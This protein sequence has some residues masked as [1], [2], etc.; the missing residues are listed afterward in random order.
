M[1]R[2]RTRHAP[3]QAIGKNSE[4]QA[5]AKLKLAHRG[6]RGDHAKSCRCRTRRNGV[7]RLSEIY[8][9]EDV[10]PLG[11]EAQ[12]EALAQTEV[13]RERQVSNPVTR[14]IEK[15]TRRTSIGGNASHDLVL[16]K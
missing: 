1:H 8:M 16:Y 10:R 2:Q 7:P 12:P 9:I 5:Q 3:P 4:T 13:A 15:I 14:S 6:G 11:P